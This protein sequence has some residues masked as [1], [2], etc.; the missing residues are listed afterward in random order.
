LYFRLSVF[1]LTLPPLRERRE[2]MALLAEAFLR[3]VTK[4]WDAQ[5]ATWS[6]PN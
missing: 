4:N 1:P 5:Y 6:A 3:R 2:V